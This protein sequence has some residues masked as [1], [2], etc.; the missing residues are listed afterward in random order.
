MSAD[1]HPTKLIGQN[2]KA[3]HLY[4]LLEFLEAGMILTGSEVKSLR[5]SK[6]AFKDSYVELVRGEAYLVGMHIAPYENAGYSQH[7]PERRRKL[8]L[9][10]REILAW[11]SK[12]EQKGLTV[13]PIR[14]YFKR[15][16]AKV[17]IALARG[18]KIYDRRDD[19]KNR[20]IARETA[21]ELSHS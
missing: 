17:E 15:G 21:R 9:H 3:R 14:M 19:I 10:T 16:K 7:D 18:K 6:V 13:V 8:L 2:K 11:T 20:D 5:A 4:E 1:Q 12:V